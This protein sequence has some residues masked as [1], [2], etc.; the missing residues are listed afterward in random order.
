MA[1]DFESRVHPASSRRRTR[2]PFKKFRRRLQ[3]LI[4]IRLFV[5]ILI[6]VT[7]IVIAL[8]LVLTSDAIDRIDTSLSN[9]N[10]ITATLGGKSGTELTLQDFSQLKLSVDDLARN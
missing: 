2:S 3:K 4:N 10:R 5:I 6:S 9:L 1:K 8:G 7:V